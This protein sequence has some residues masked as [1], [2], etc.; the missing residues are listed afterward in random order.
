MSAKHDHVILFRVFLNGFYNILWITFFYHHLAVQ[1]LPFPNIKPAKPRFIMRP[2]DSWNPISSENS[3]ILLEL[4][5]DPKKTSVYCLW[6]GNPFVHI[7]ILWCLLCLFFSSGLLEFSKKSNFI[8]EVDNIWHFWKTLNLPGF[9][10]KPCFHSYRWNIC[11]N[12]WIY[13][14]FFRQK[15]ISYS[16]LSP[17]KTQATPDHR[18]KNKSS[19]SGKLSPWCLGGVGH[20]LPDDWYEVSPFWFAA[21]FW[22]VGKFCPMSWVTR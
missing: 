19:F 13:S 9:Q 7:C 10:V 20:G 17:K 8:Q 18:T 15:P 3:N 11:W 22:A 21:S 6:F 2:P 4:T 16:Q 5:P 14:F 12:L 1:I